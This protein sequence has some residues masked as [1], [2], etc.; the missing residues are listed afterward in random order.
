M[1]VR[2]ERNMMGMENAF[3]INKSAL[4]EYLYAYFYGFFAHSVFCCPPTAVPSV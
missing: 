4:T 2:T 3:M 1:N